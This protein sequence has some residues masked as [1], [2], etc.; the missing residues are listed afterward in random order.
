MGSPRMIV[1]DANW[2][3]VY[4][5]ACVK[6]RAVKHFATHVYQELYG[7][8]SIFEKG[9]KPILCNHERFKVAQ[10]AFE[11]L[12]CPNRWCDMIFSRG[13]CIPRH[14]IKCVKPAAYNV[15]ANGS[16]GSQKP[17]S[18]YRPP[19]R[20]RSRMLEAL[21]FLCTP[22]RQKYVCPRI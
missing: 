19:R 16:E 20:W 7:P 8:P 17:T 22:R 3:C 9:F 11:W 2:F 5:G 15:V 10:E 21:G 1:A 13:D 18:Q 4:S 6:G 12:R 14:L